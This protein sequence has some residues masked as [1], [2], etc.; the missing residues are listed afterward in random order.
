MARPPLQIM[1]TVWRLREAKAHHVA[2]QFPEGLLMYACAIS[3]IL[4][5]F[6]PLEETFIMGDVTYG[7][8]CIDDFSASALGA[9][10]LV[11]Y[12]HSCL[13]PVSVTKVPC[14]YIFVEI[15]IDLQHLVDTVVHNFEQEQRILLAGT[16]QFS[17]AIQ[18]WLPHACV[19]ARCWDRMVAA[20]VHPSSILCT[21]T[22]NSQTTT[23]SCGDMT[24]CDTSRHQKFQCSHGHRRMYACREPSCSSKKG[25][26]EVSPFHRTGPCQR[27]RR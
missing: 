15:E 16:I 1:K 8:C 5:A 10:F 18:V 9:D 6:T 22:S 27:G 23:S 14:M 21:T 25:D 19:R 2:L 3:D 20:S 12:G 13:V 17:T 26:S 11:H 4:E 7:A 24:D